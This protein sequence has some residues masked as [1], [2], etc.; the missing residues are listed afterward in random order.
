[1][2][3]LETI[4]SIVG[5]AGIGIKLAKTL[6]QV[7]HKTANANHNINRIATNVSLFASML[8]HV[9]SVLDDAHSL[10][11]PD[12]VETVKQ[13][14]REC[15]STF[16]EIADIIVLARDKSEG[17]KD[18]PLANG[19]KRRI[20][21]VARAKWYF[22]GPKAEHLLAQLEYLKTTLSVLL[23]TLNL[24]ALTAKVNAT[25]GHSEKSPEIVQQER[26]HVETLIV[27]QQ[28]SVH[29]L[30]ETQEK[31]GA[32]ST[33]PST[34]SEDPSLESRYHK[35]LTQGS[36]TSLQMVRL[37]N[38]D[39]E[40]LDR[41]PS[42]ANSDG[43]PLEHSNSRPEAFIDDLLAK[44]TVGPEEKLL[45]PRENGT[46]EEEEEEEEEEELE[47]QATPVPAATRSKP[48]AP[49]VTGNASSQ[50]VPNVKIAPSTSPP[51]VAAVSP[52]TRPPSQ[53]WTS[54]RSDIA[55]LASRDVRS[56]RAPSSLD[57]APSET[58]SSS[59]SVV[60]HPLR[61]TLERSITNP[62]G[63]GMPTLNAFHDHHSLQPSSSANRNA[64]TSI[65]PP[66]LAQH[67]RAPAP[68]YANGLG[69]LMAGAAAASGNAH[70]SPGWGNYRQPYVSDEDSTW[71][72]SDSDGSTPSPQERKSPVRP[73]RESTTSTASRHGRHT[74]QQGARRGD[75]GD[76]LGIP[77]RIRISSSKYF[78]FRDDMLVGP[79]TPYL[80]SEH[81]SW[82][83]SQEHAYTELSKKWVCEEALVEMR[84]SHTELRDEHDAAAIAGEEG[85]WRILSPLK[86]VRSFCATLLSSTDCA[87]SMRLNP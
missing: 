3:G 36:Q 64:N 44:W 42:L 49:E 47:R 26:L 86:F 67:Q 87:C 9:G 71:S 60:T 33:R 54:P 14:V 28:L 40:F 13:I 12:A 38:A 25:L 59:P 23:Q 34:P 11:S 69:P 31:L 85:G 78:D 55:T 5:I 73:R 24:A 57:Y 27:A 41:R 43:A 75:A 35:L 17:S 51:A 21:M 83:F 6:Y 32:E 29:S 22:E 37:G 39:L 70:L 50:P 46:I 58:S 62:E 79:R 1:M 76:G 7:G 77:W 74:S 20:N 80:P 81:R 72:P 4:A 52:T 18:P 82:I 65:P 10:H 8:K 61:G 68:Y 63:D 66:Q 56:P 15:E 48:D 53:Q 30:R 19:S 16:K 84:Y 2:A 45:R